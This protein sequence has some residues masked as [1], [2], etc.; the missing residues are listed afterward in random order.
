MLGGE[1]QSGPGMQNAQHGQPAG[2]E[3]A[4]PVPVE[5]VALAA[6]PQLRCPPAR[7]PIPK[8]WQA[9]EVPRYRRIV[10][11]ALHDRPQPLSRARGRI[12]PTLPKLRLE[13]LPLLP[14]SPTDRR[15]LHGKVPPPV[16]PADMREAQKVERL[17]LAFSA[18]F[19][20]EFG[21]PPELDPARFVR[22][23]FQSKLPQPFPEVLQATVGFRL[24]LESQD[25]IIGLA[26]DD[27][28]PSG[29]LLSPPLHPAV[30]NVMQIDIRPQG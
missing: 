5:A 17:R 1:P 8:G 7:Q 26:P 19:P 13:F 3:L 24:R 9:V 22:M 23:Q 30:E 21:V 28:I 4:H 16:L 15:A 14:Q 25:G 20:A 27:H 6:S 2:S 18:S 10:E 29:V 12:V 11:V